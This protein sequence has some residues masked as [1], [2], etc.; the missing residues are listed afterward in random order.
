MEVGDSDSSSKSAAVWMQHVEVSGSLGQKRI[1]F[2][3]SDARV[4]VLDDL[5]DAGIDA[6]VFNKESLGQVINSGSEFS[7]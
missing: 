5:V 2:L 3:G 1:K 6:H 7:L 4:S